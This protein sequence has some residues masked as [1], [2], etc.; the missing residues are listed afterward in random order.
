MRNRIRQELLPLLG[1]RFNP[2]AVEALA[3][4]A[5]R[6]IEA[7]SFIDAR[8]G[9]ALAAVLLSSGSGRIVLDAIRLAAYDGGLHGRVLRA[10]CSLIMSRPLSEQH[11]D[12]LVA[13]A[14]GQRGEVTLP[15]G[16]R[17]LRDGDRVIIE[18]R[19]VQKP[20]GKGDTSF[21]RGESLAPGAVPTGQLDPASPLKIPGCTP[22]GPIADREGH[23]SGNPPGESFLQAWVEPATAGTAS[24]PGN[25]IALDW[26]ALVPPLAARHPR[27]GDRM[28]PLGFRHRRKLQDILVDRKVPREKRP[29]LWVVE[30]QERI[31]WVVGIVRSEDARVTGGTARQLILEEQRA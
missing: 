27:P 5:D 3:R 25:R 28:R 18:A 21:R 1:D 19:Q 17:A 6:W 12:S 2:R 7:D 29:G 31:L 26:D 30:D 13:L 20:P 22:L 4:A 15:E 11:T 9:E 10:A 24:L 16:F 8:A 14:C 23:L